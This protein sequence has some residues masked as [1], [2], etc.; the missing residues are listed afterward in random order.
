MKLRL[1]RRAVA[2][3]KQIKS[4]WRNNRPDSPELF[5]HELD[6]V[7]ARIAAKGGMIGS[8]Y[9]EASLE[10]LVRKVLLPKTN[11]HVYYAVE[12]DEI[13]VI[14]IWGA[15]KEGARTEA[16]AAEEAA[17]SQDSPAAGRRPRSS[18]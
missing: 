16:V 15:P 18:A 7:L 8:L 6:A 9:E 12:G 4:W 11:N 14:S 5:E 2:E 3:A 10:V 1:A 13:V 17:S